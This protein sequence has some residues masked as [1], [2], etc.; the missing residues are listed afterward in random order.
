MKRRRLLLL[1]AVL[2]SVVTCA[3][4]AASPPQSDVAPRS[5][6]AGTSPLFQ[7]IASADAALSAAFNAHDVDGLMAS[8][9]DDLE[10]FHDTDGLQKYA[11][12]RRSFAALFAQGN[13]IRR[14]LVAETLRVYPLKDYGAIELGQHRFCHLENGSNECGTFEFVHVW[15]ITKGKW[16]IARVVS[17]GHRG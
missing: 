3:A 2:S 1:T 12:V 5:G 4:R 10:F 16:Q 7:A 15:K 14:E 9:T 13:G 17:Y 6:E 11:E 8:F